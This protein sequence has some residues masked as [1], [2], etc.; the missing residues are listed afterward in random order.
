MKKLY[1]AAIIT[2]TGECL[3]HKDIYIS[4]GR[5]TRICESGTIQPDLAPSETIDCSKYFVSPGFVNLHAHTAMNIFKGI[6]EDVPPEI[7]FNEMIWPYESKMTEQDIYTGTMLGIAEMINNGVTAVADHY[8]G[9]DQVLQAAKDSGI[10]MDIAPT[11]FGMAPDFRDRLAQVSEFIR[12]HQEDSSRISLRFGPH[13]DYTCPEDTLAVVV[14]E[15]KKMDLPI[16]LHL[17]ETQLQ[18][19]QSLQRTGKTPFRCLYDTGGFELPVLVAHGLWI[20]EDDLALI[21]RNT[22]FAFCPK[23]YMRLASGRGGFFDFSDRLQY[24]F[25][26]DGAASSGTVNPLEQARLFAMLEK[27]NRND[28]VIYPF[29]EIWKRLMAGHAV[30]G[31]NSGK[32]EENAAADLVIWDLQTPDTMAYY[33]PVS[34][35]LYAAT[36]ANVRYT[37]VEGEFLKYDGVLKMDFAGIAEESM[38][39]QKNLLSRGKGTA[40]VYY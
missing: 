1:N 40:K 17:A 22:W 7:W 33:H 30:F 6:A 32:M 24:S 15:A 9:E 16:H 25:G 13:S 11:I 37:M 34:A 26:S 36:S 10:R 5:I 14:D 29:L 20:T 3:F 8:F 31:A 2:E 28:A 27:F 19:E 39:L 38:R 35:I 12:N 21:N 23:T 4:D 18:V